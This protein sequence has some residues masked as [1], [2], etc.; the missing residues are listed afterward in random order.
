MPSE[1]RSVLKSCLAKFVRLDVCGNPVVGAASVL[2]TKGYISVAATAQIETGEEFILKNACGELC[3]NEKDCDQF[4]RYDLELQ[5]CQIDPELLELI[6]N[7]RLLVDSGG[8]SRGFAHGESSLCE[9]FSLELWNKVT[10]SACDVDGDPEWYY[11]AF[12]WV[13]NGVMTDVTFENGPLTL[14][15]T[16]HTKGAGPGWGQGPS[17]VLSSDSP[18]ISTDHLLGYITNVQPPAVECGLQ[19]L[20]A[21]DMECVAESV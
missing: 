17:C 6:S 3:I 4:K 5:L 15:L 2:T 9:N 18:A 11:F 1:C 12:P 13:T 21:E 19:A 7:A 20:A 8:T 10:P 16:A 14:S